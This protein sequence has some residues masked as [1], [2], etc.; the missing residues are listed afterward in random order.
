MCAAAEGDQAARDRLVSTFTPLIASVAR[1]YRGNAT[2]ERGELMQ[3]G[4]AGLLT[5]LR[6]YDPELGTPFWAYA[7]WWVRRA[8]QQFVAESTRSI[9]LSDRALGRLARIRE[10][11]RELA[12]GGNVEPTTGDLTQATG[13]P[14]DQVESLLAAERG[15]RGLEEPV[16]GDEGP[17]ATIGELIADPVAEDEYDRVFDRFD[18]RLLSELVESLGDRDRGIVYA[19]YGLD[20]PKQTLR[21]IAEVLEISVERVRQLE[22]RA[23]TTLRDGF[24]TPLAA[25]GSAR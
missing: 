2:V 7:S 10:A 21:E 6:R 11:R 5:A 14:V 4:V 13:L 20:R 18:L 3:E 25:Q 12:R 22:E 1:V 24:D 16:S 23:L 15:A 17:T 19:H 8:M 9:V